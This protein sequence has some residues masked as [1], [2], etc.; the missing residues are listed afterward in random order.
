[1]DSVALLRQQYQMMHYM[2][3]GTMAELTPEQAHWSPPG[4]AKP[5]AAE[6]AHVIAAEDALVNG[7]LQQ[8][9]PLATT[10]W[11]G[12]T[13]LSELPPMSSSWA[14]WAGQVRVDLAE[15]RDYAQAV[16]ANT[17]AFFAGLSDDEL[18]VVSDYSAIGFGENPMSFV[19][20]MMAADGA[21]HCG[22]ISCIKGLQMLK[23][24]PF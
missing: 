19:L 14:T 23:G 5:I 4:V 3:E 18:S 8:S 21:A 10:E 13:G 6:Y 2:L 16:Y 12:R 22:E 24:Y 9:P 1:M 11:A 15:A 7:V 17:D 20:N